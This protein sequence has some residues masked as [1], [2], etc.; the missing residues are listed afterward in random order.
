MTR[1][2]CRAARVKAAID[3]TAEHHARNIAAIPL[4]PVTPG[5]RVR[6][7]A[8]L[9]ARL[10]VDSAEHVA[11]FGQSFGVVIGHAEGDWPEVDVRW[12]PSGLRYAYLPGDLEAV[13]AETDRPKPPATPGM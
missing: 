10:A 6:M 5:T 2:H 12:E 1:N 11:E 7:S 13:A 4:E 9:R 3:W 8:A